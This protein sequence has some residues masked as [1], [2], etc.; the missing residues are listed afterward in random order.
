M[1]RTTILCVLLAAGCRG[2]TGAEPAGVGSTGPCPS[3]ACD[4]DVGC[5]DEDCEP[6]EG[7]AGDG[8][9]G[10][11]DEC[12]SGGDVPEGDA[13]ELATLEVRNDRGVDRLDEVAHSAIPIAA[14]D[15]LLDPSTLVVVDGDRRL[16]AQFDVIGRWGGPV[17]DEALP[18]RWLGV[19][20]QTDVAADTSDRYALLRY[21]EPVEAVDG[22]IVTTMAGEDTVQI[23]TGVAQFSLGRQEPGLLSAAVLGAEVYD[24]ASGAGGPRLS[25]AD[26]TELSVGQGNVVVDEGGFEIIEQGPVR[27]VVKQSGHFTHPTHPDVRVDCVGDGSEPYDRFTYTVLM[28]FTRGSGDIGLQIHFANECSD[29]FSGPWTDQAVTVNDMSWVLPLLG[30]VGEVTASTTGDLSTHPGAQQV[31]VEQRKGGTEATW[32]SRS[33]QLVV[34]GQVVSEAT[35]L[36]QPFLA[37]RTADHV[38]AIAMPWMRF[39]EP[40]ALAFEDGA[41]VLRVVSDS[42]VVGEGKA[43]WNFAKVRFSPADAVDSVDALAD[44][45]DRIAAELERGLLVRRPLSEFNA[46]QVYPSM[47]DDSTSMVKTKYL[48]MLSQLHDDTVRAG[49]QWD[50]AKTYG[51]Q[52][53]PDNQFDPWVYADGLDTPYDNDGAMNYWNPAGA[54]L[55]E[56]FRSGDPKYVWEFALPQSYLQMHSAYVNI[57]EHT[58]GNR[59]GFAA[60]SGGSGEGQWH[61]S[62][63]GSADYSYN[64]AIDEAY[65]IRPDALMRRR[66]AHAGATVRGVYTIPQAQQTERWDSNYLAVDR[67]HMQRFDMLAN[68][69]EFVPGD[70]GRGCHDKLAEIMAEIAEDN[71]SAGMICQPDLPSDVCWAPQQFMLNSM[72]YGTLMRHYLNYGGDALRRALVEAPRTLYR[73]GMDKLADGETLDVTGDWAA[74]MMCQLSA[75]RTEVE[76]CERIEVEG[77][78]GMFG[79]NRPQTLALLLMSDGLDDADGLC[80]IARQA[81]DESIYVPLEDYVSVG[82]GGGWWKGSSQMMQSLVFAV[83]GYD[84]CG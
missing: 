39:R 10:G 21:A 8:T 63:Q 64:Q 26:G 79:H 62:G 22:A 69:A 20:V 56:F 71:L 5:D 31:V 14:A 35:A 53:W 83:G 82:G 43:L 11:C 68:C 58:H 9:T 75:D 36:E 3:L 70:E 81:L 78:V 54:E 44:Q 18:I 45:R 4:D 66:F 57:G 76:A 15:E 38:V 19:A 33:S 73:L 72:M 50:R 23:D 46:T 55:H 2:S 67:F 34:D 40:Q 84:V 49:G 24:A 25:L 77:S 7:T 32:S 74:Q 61:R 1:K 41:L 30:D 16:A 17:S 29:A 51:S 52:L 60:I 6:T 27:V 12:D 65:V 48:E 13:E 28:T 80:S 42:L 37:A 47:G 59:N